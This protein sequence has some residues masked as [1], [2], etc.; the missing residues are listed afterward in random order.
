MKIVDY[1]IP[2]RILVS[3]FMLTR[4]IWPAKWYVFILYYL[5]FGISVSFS[6][7]QTFTQKLN[8]AKVYD[9][10]PD[11][12][13]YVDKFECKSIVAGIIGQEYVVPCYGVWDNFDEINFKNLP[14]QFILKSTHDS[15][16]ICICRD[17]KNFDKDRG[18]R[19]INKSLN[20]DYYWYGREWPYKK[21]SRRV[22]ADQLLDDGRRGELQDYKWWCYNGEPRVMYITNKGVAGKIYENFY[23]MNFQPLSIKRCY[24]RLLPEYEKPESFE[25][26]KELARKLSAGFGFIR[27]DFFDIHGKIYFGEFTFYDHAGFLPFENE[28]WDIELGSWYEV[29]KC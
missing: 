24:P 16:G 6:T 29:Q 7:P 3:F 11:Y 10:N 26:M 23:D 17:K 19:V 9:R 5:K 14:D 18:R 20:T 4:K 22:I 25:L 21:A 28:Q 12:W 8:W 2:S 15:S 27:I 1:M 13:R